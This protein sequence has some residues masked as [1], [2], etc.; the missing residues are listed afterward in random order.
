[1]TTLSPFRRALYPIAVVACAGAVSPGCGVDGEVLPTD[2]ETETSATNV[3]VPVDLCNAAK[4]RL[5]IQP[6]GTVAVQ[7]IT[8]G[9]SAAQCFT[10]LEGAPFGL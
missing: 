1:M 2:L 3:Y 6:G 9:V 4:G 7:T 5:F 8:G 10:S